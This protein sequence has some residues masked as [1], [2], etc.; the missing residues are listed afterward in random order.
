MKWSDEANEIV[1]EL[2]RE[3]PAPSRALVQEVM[4]LRAE[5]LSDE[6]GEDEVSMETAVQ[7]FVE[8]T[9]ADLRQRLKHTLTYHG[10]DPED[11]A[12]AFSSE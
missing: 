8:S 11:Y 3:L 5:T 10:I 12:A 2:L 4:E 9:P 7:A 1:E 6:A